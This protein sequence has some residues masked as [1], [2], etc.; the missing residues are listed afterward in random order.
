M[1]KNYLLTAWR[2]LANNQLFSAIN[3]FGLSVGLMSCILI[4]MFVQ[5]EMSYDKWLK[6]GDRLV[7]M[8]TAYYSPDR[9]PFLT[10]R[11]AGRMM[12]AISNYAPDEIE[13]GVRLLQSGFTVIL[14]DKVF[15]EDVVFADGTFF[16][17]FTLPFAHG[18]AATAF[19]KPM[20]LI[21]TEEKAIK[22]FGRTDVVGEQ[23][24]VCCLEGERFDVQITGVI[25]DLPENTHLDLSFLTYLEPSMFD[26]APNLLN[27]WTSVNTYTYFKLNED[28]SPTD[29]KER[30]DY[31]LNNESPLTGMVPEGVTP[32]EMLHL[33]FMKVPDLHLRA[34]HDAGN[35]GDLKP[36]GDINMVYAF[37]GVALLVLLIAS[38]NFMN[39]STARASRRAREVALRKVMGASRLQVAFQFLGE[40]V[41]IAVVSLL[42]ALVAVEAVMPF[43]NE[44][45]GRELSLVVTEEPLMLG[46]LF[47]IAIIVGLLSGSYPAVYLSRFLPARIM[48]ANQS[49][50]AGGQGYLRSLLVVFQF[51]VSI[52]LAVCTAV[53]YGQTLFARGMDV[54]YEYEQKL[55][56]QGLNAAEVRD[57]QRALIN[58]LERVPGVSSVVLSS[59]V[60][61]QDNE[62]NTGF[63]LLDGASEGGLDESVILNYYTAGYGFFEAYDMQLLAGRTF[64]EQFGTDIID[65]IPHEEERIGTASVIINESAMT[66][67]GFS[68]PEEAIGKTLRAD[69]FRSGTH[70]LTIVGVAKDIHFRS[71]KFGIRPSVFFNNP[72]M[73]R[74]ATISFTG[75]PTTVISAVESVWKKMAPSTPINHR[76][77]ADMVHE[78][79]RTEEKQAELF[80]VF[81]IL[82]VII[83][84]LG[85]FG[86]ASFTAERRTREI[87]IRKVMG[88]RIRDIITMLIWQFSLPVL[89]ANIV[90]WPLA[91]ILM[92]NWLESFTYR[93]DSSFILLASLAAG[94]SALII[95]WLTVAARAIR[96]ASASPVVALRYE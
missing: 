96:V 93:I 33:K 51:S 64:D 81:S 58:E 78:Q 92:N 50:E 8:H 70:D 75:N 39:L 47:L 26:F 44:A 76:F 40:A 74:V 4:L 45:I 20:D 24:T 11:S 54:G 55:V 80:A 16:D 85:L 25:R 71:I 31:W 1:L 60:P 34:K 68:E 46:S 73:L 72:M 69:V 52:G 49:S 38:I 22:Y 35:L 36:L 32:S 89:I 61:S 30:V 15:D 67:L 37:S 5:N 83:A 12:E 7:R 18:S 42:F 66:R 59:E 23:L 13:T 43:Y 2:H 29:L 91:W 41:A 63:T 21:V 27:T 48:K 6:D 95:A 65:A 86:L 57:Q 3:I 94:A 53:I 77:L 88:A 17:V 90:A 10:I 84:C 82:A 62:N 28:V 56:L 14:D 79:Y 87:G 19:S 9:P